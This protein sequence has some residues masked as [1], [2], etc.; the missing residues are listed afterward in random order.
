[1]KV[2]NEFGSGNETIS[3]PGT[4]GRPRRVRW[5]RDIAPRRTARCEVA[6][7]APASQQ[8]VSGFE[9]FTPCRVVSIRGICVFV[10]GLME[11][12]KYKEIL[13]RDGSLSSPGA[14]G[15]RHWPEGQLS[16]RAD[17]MSAS[18]LAI[19]QR[20][21]GLYT[22]RGGV[23]PGGH[24][25]RPHRC[26]SYACTKGFLIRRWEPIL[27]WVYWLYVRSPANKRKAS[28]GGIGTPCCAVFYPGDHRFCPQVVG[29][30]KV[31]H[32]WFRQ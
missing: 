28:C 21:L 18:Q 14:A 3:S 22:V 5:D 17:C 20:G 24:R 31:S 8:P 13:I 7:Y 10:P 2:S 4:I 23:D 11:L 12:Y 27:T 19:T 1:M 25:I 15:P 6:R 9:V 16:W 26:P 32:E 30:V 29:V